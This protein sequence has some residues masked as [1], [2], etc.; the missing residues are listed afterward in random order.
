MK[1]QGDNRDFSNEVSKQGIKREELGQGEKFDILFN[2]LDKNVKGDGMLDSKEIAYGLSI[3]GAIARK[4]DKGDN[5]VVE[6]SEL[7]AAVMGKI[8]PFGKMFKKE[9]ITEED[10][11]AFMSKML[12]LNDTKV[13]QDSIKAKQDFA[14]SKGMKSLDSNPSIAIDKDNKPVFIYEM[15]ESFSMFKDGLLVD[16]KSGFYILPKDL[17]T[18]MGTLMYNKGLYDNENNR[19]PYGYDGTE[20]GYENTVKYARAN[21]FQETEHKY[22]FTKE[23]KQYIYHPEYQQFLTIDKITNSNDN[24]SCVHVKSYVKE[25]TGHC[26]GHDQYRDVMQEFDMGFYNN[27][28]VGSEAEYYIAK[29]NLK[30]EV[31][32]EG[33]K[34]TYVDKNDKSI[35]YEYKGNGQ[36]S[37]TQSVKIAQTKN[38]KANGVLDA[39]IYQKGVGDCYLVASLQG[40]RKYLPNTFKNSGVIQQDGDNYIVRFPG[41][42]EAKYGTSNTYTVTSADVAAD[43]KAEGK[44]S[45]LGDPDAIIIEEAFKQF[46]FDLYSNERAVNRGLLEEHRANKDSFLESPYNF[47]SNDSKSAYINL[48][49]KSNVKSYSDLGNDEDTRKLKAGLLEAGLESAVL[50]A[51]LPPNTEIQTIIIGSAEAGGKTAAQLIDEYSNNGYIVFAGFKPGDPKYERDKDGHVVVYDNEAKQFISTYDPGTFD[52]ELKSED[53]R[54]RKITDITVVKIPEADRKTP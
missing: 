35:E 15:G 26:Y 14:K 12:E 32:K 34:T 44:T 24:G 51:L 47:K 4:N 52:F 48:T 37:V 19:V 2:M 23:G 10:L 42:G 28:V 50:K 46:R 45:S 40:I 6:D 43:K 27:N 53:D 38:Q 54:N 3:F 21:G 31:K 1:I 13:K 11:K 18:E 9:D 7:S 49:D 30:I 29:D 20:Q 5:N 8:F 25:R 16:E 41:L 39:P 22:I 17:R 33:N 36:F